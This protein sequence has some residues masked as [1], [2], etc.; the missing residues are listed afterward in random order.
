MKT[1]SEHFGWPVIGKVVT[2]PLGMTRTAADGTKS[3]ETLSSET[4]DVIGKVKSRDG[5][6]TAFVANVWYR[7]EKLEPLLLLEDLVEKFEP[8]SPADGNVEGTK[9]AKE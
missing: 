9:E 5:N 4:Y 8:S 2:K 6:V 7:E 1:P 3:Q